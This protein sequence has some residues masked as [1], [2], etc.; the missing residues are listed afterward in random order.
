MLNYSDNTTFYTKNGFIV[1]DPTAKVISVKKNN[2]R[3]SDKHEAYKRNCAVILNKTKTAFDEYTET[4]DKLNKRFFKALISSAV[5]IF[6][7]I[8]FLKYFTIGMVVFSDGRHIASAASMQAYE[9]ALGIAKKRS[10]DSG[11]AKKMN[12]NVFPAVL[13]RSKTN[14]PTEVSNRILLTLPEFQS[15]YTLYSDGKPIYAA[16]SKNE[17]EKVL[18]SYVK[19]YSMNGEAEITSDVVIKKNVLKKEEIMEYDNCLKALKESDAVNVVSVVNSTIEEALPYST[20]TQTDENL[21]IGEKITVTKGITGKKEISQQT[22]YKNGAAQSN[23][24]HSEKVIIEPVSEV[25]KIGV[26]EKNILESGVI[27]PLAQRGVISSR[28][29]KRWGNIHEG[30]D[31]AIET[32]TEVLAAECGTVSY[33]SENAGG[34]GKYIKIDHGN[35]L[36]T[37]YAHL[38][39]IEVKKGQAVRAGERIAL[40]G[41]TGRSTGPHL[42]F[43]IVQ[44]GNQIDPEPYMK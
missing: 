20:Q 36:E 31:I 2:R 28:F 29:G 6:C 7:L 13:L 14:P 25:I 42:H 12:Y 32:G 18:L 39:M 1:S 3:S 21:Y 10:S 5:A 27:W 8:F 40:S 11:N 26:R 33:I 35:N 41:N 19:E 22:I 16:A 43:E 37:A 24:I 44:S 17:A 23:E 30:I 4:A 9:T 15:A 38:D 34:Y